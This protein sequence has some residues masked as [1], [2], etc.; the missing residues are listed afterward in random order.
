MTVNQ[1][2]LMRR[3]MKGVVTGSVNPD[4]APPR[5]CNGKLDNGRPCRVIMLGDEEYCIRHRNEIEALETGQPLRP[6]HMERDQ[7]SQEVQD[8]AKYRCGKTDCS[9]AVKNDGEMCWQHKGLED[10]VAAGTV[11][12]G[13]V[14]AANVA[15]ASPPPQALEEE[16]ATA[17]PSPLARLLRTLEPIVQ[18]LPPTSMVLDFDED[19]ASM[20]RN[21]DLT[22]ADL[23]ELTLMLLNGELGRIVEVE[24]PC[25]KSRCHAA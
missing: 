11:D 15:E 22:A 7:E 18:P 17:P 8:V 1:E 4:P 21:S 3:M 6:G 9:R 25:A 14:C 23:K 12:Q 19:E 2:M 20:I 13:A 10:Q 16:P 5:Y 24:D